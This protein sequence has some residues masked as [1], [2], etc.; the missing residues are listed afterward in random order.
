MKKTGKEM[1]AKEIARKLGTTEY[2]VKHSLK[3]AIKKLK[4]GRADKIRDLSIAREREQTHGLARIVDYG[5]M[6]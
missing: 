3:S 5:D 6:T 2:S 1:T 4:D